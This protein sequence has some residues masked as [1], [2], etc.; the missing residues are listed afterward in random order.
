MAGSSHS[1]H[2]GATFFLFLLYKIVIDLHT[3]FPFSHIDTITRQQCMCVSDKLMHQLV[4][5]T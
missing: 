3:Q 1:K 2:N 4:L 5:N